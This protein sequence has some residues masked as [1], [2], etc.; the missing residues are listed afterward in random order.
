M[1]NFIKLLYDKYEDIILYLF[2]GVMATILNIVLYELFVRVFH[3]HYIVANG[4]DWILCVLFAYYTNR[5]FVFRSQIKDAKGI[6]E[7]FV[8]FFSCRIVSGVMDMGIMVGMV[9]LLHMD[10][11]IAKLVTQVVVVVSNYVFSKLFIFRNKE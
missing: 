7:E 11:S 10:G 9:E 3:M 8:K 1:I 5:T 2:W 6:M 4:L